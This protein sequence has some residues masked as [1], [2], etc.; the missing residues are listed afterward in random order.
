MSVLSLFLLILLLK[1][2][3]ESRGLPV[4]QIFKQLTPGKTSHSDALLDL[5]NSQMSSS[6]IYG[7]LEKTEDKIFRNGTEF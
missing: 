3:P 6:T 4:D 7:S 1:F 2:M 5:H